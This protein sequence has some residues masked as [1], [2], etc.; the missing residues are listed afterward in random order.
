MKLIFAVL[1]VSSTVGLTRCY[2]TE[3]FYAFMIVISYCCTEQMTYCLTLCK[4]WTDVWTVGRW[5][6]IMTVVL[7]RD[8]TQ[9]AHCVALS[10]LLRADV[11]LNSHSLNQFA[12]VSVRAESVCLAVYVA[13][14]HIM[15][16]SLP[17]LKP[18]LDND[19]LP[20]PDIRSVLH[21]SC[22]VV[23]LSC[24]LCLDEETCS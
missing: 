20:F 19:F 16:F 7:R 12:C 3:G 2:K 9:N 21:C 6:S 14:G 18:L 5:T 10:R 22:K 4:T 13:N 11:P 15:A 23:C 17:S 8:A 24:M 1:D